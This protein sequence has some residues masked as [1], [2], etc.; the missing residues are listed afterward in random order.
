MLACLSRAVG[1]G[2]RKGMRVVLRMRMKLRMERLRVRKKRV[3]I[4]RIV[5]FSRCCID[6]TR[7]WFDRLS[8]AFCFILHG[9]AFP[10]FGGGSIHTYKDVLMGLANAVE[11][12]S[13][14]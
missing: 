12:P 1:G 2:T 3:E 5:C 7:E 9:M 10:F 11:Q 4:V 13:E 6:R 14:R 8:F